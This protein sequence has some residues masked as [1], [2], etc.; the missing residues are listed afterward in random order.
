MGNVLEMR[1][2]GGGVCDFAVARSEAG[3]V[4]PPPPSENMPKLR[5][6]GASLGLVGGGDRRDLA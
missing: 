6:W 4:K 3:V 1:D 5:C 2:L